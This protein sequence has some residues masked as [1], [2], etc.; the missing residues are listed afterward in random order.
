MYNEEYM[1]LAIEEAKKALNLDE[2]PIGVVIV[3]D[4][5]VIACGFNQKNTSNIVTRHAE[6][7][8]IEEANRVLGNWRLL[9]CELYVTLEPCP[10]CMSAIQQARISK[11][12]YGVE[13]KDSINSDIINMISRKSNTNPPVELYGGFLQSEITLLLTAFFKKKR[14]KQR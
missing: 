3:K 7:I 11:V 8:A 12:Y 6:I 14:E 9:D 2:V 1:R 4:Q 10:M 5:E 13:N